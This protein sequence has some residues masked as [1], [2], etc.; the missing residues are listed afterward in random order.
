MFNGSRVV[1]V[2]AAIAAALW[3]AAAYARPLLPDRQPL[4][5]SPSMLQTTAP[6]RVHHV[7][8][9]TPAGFSWHDA[10]FG[11]AGM[12]VLLSICAA[13]AAALRRRSAHPATS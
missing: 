9:A 13:A 1:V 7:A 10:G 3:P 6:A 2:V 5:V 12:L 11:A 8:A 4:F